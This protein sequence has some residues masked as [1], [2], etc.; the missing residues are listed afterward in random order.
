MFCYWFCVSR[1]APC[2]A[3]KR[4]L[5]VKRPP[6]VGSSDLCAKGQATLVEEVGADPADGAAGKETAETAREEEPDCLERSFE[7]RA[8]IYFQFHL[9]VPFLGLLGLVGLD[10]GTRKSLFAFKKR[11]QL[12]ENNFF[13][14]WANTPTFNKAAQL[15]G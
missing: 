2:V 15:R 6:W 12:I 1:N 13:G 3:E 7:H 4:V 9:F 14:V 10:L 11:K 5:G 8:P